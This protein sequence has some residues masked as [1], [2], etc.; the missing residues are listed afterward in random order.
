LRRQPVDGA[1]L[2]ARDV[3]LDSGLK[4]RTAALAE[5]TLRGANNAPATVQSADLATPTPS[6]SSYFQ[7]SN[8]ERIGREQLAC[9]RIGLNPRLGAF[10][11]CVAGLRAAMFAAD[12]PSN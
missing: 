1:V 9:A 3:C 10:D 12:N 7:A 2:A 8:R 4:E 11:S 5:C 6:A